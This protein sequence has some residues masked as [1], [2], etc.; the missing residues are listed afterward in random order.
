[1]ME[2][3]VTNSDV[4]L[5]PEQIKRIFTKCTRDCTPMGY[6]YD[7]MMRKKIKDAVRHPKG[8]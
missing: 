1:M 4:C 5:T 3:F 8:R 7:E 6:I 2:T